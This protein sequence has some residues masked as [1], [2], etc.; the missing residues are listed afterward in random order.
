MQRLPA[1][2]FS[3]IAVLI[4]GA[5]FSVA[6]HLYANGIDVFN[7][8]AIRYGVGVLGM[9]ALLI[10][11]EG[12]DKLAYRGD[13]WRLATLGTIGFA[14]FNLLVFVGLAHSEPAH[15]AI[16]VAM[17]PLIAA[18]VRWGRD[19]L[20][21]PVQTLIAIGVALVGVA[22]VVTKGEISSGWGYGEALALAGVTGWVFYTLGADDHPGLSPLRYTTLTAIPGTLVIVLITA[23]ADMAGWQRLPS[24]SDV[25]DQ[26]AGL[27]F[28]TVLAAIIAVLAWNTGVRRLGAPNATL[29]INLV[30]VI[31]LAISIAEGYKPVAAEYIGTALV[32]AALIGSNLA[33]RRPAR[34]NELAPSGALT[35]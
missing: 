18:T 6:E 9:I 21:P 13:F 1:P 14:G 28:I 26:W 23:V 4:W 32:I 31:A 22:L 19:G 15:V 24:G 8:T 16:I 5:M 20:K 29:F 10:A 33:A 7:M 11:F 2:S 12:R 27:L 3:L 35:K 25:I 34:S 17:M 30:P